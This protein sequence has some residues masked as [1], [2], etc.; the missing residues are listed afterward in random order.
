VELARHSLPRLQT[1]NQ[2]YL[3]D[4]AGMT[5]S[6]LPDS[7]KTIKEQ[8]GQ[9]M[10]QL[11]L[12]YDEERVYEEGT[13][14]I[15]GDSHGKH[16]KSRMFN[17][18]GHL[19]DFL[20]PNRVIHIGHA[21]DD[22]NDFSYLWKDIDNFTILAKRE[23]LSTLATINER[24]EE[25]GDQAYDIVRGEISLGDL[26]VANQDMIS[27]YVETFI[28]HIKRQILPGNVVTNLH[29]QELDSRTISVG[30]SIILSPGC[31]CENHIVKTIRQMDFT[32]GIQVK[33]SYPDGF[34]K[35]RK[36]RHKF[37]FWE[38]GLV[39]VHV[40]SNGKAYPIQCRIKQTS[41]GYTTSYMGTIVS[42]KGTHKPD[43]K[44]FMT[45]DA[46]CPFQD[47]NAL[48]IQRQIAASYSP[49]KCVNLGDIMRNQSFNHHQMTKNGA[50]IDALTAERA[51]DMMDESAH[52][53]WVLKKQ[54]EWADEFVLMY[55]NH[56]RFARDFVDR[57]PQLRTILDVTFTG[58]LSEL[59]LL[60]VPLKHV[61]EDGPVRFL[62][63]DIRMYGAKGPMMDKIAHTFGQ[64]SVVGHLHAPAIRYGCYMVGMS[65]LF[66]QEYNEPAACKWMHGCGVCDIFDGQAFISLI[67]I[68][69]YETCIGD[70]VYSPET[71]DEWD[72]PEYTSSISYSFSEE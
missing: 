30:H 3:L 62:H 47:N 48:D 59:D 35:Y 7:F 54:R 57:Y 15:V 37:R 26:T 40:D 42:E 56:E 52:V 6:D 20:K 41:K 18:L 8:A 70:T 50:H 44:H 10:H 65:G 13:Y 64:S 49:D 32:D 68:R 60:L 58:G 67:H 4:K 9:I 53:H 23:E 43:K 39:V 63:G 19:C 11:G 61:H 5:K 2:D 29:R 38:Q 45:T 71:P 12:G 25:N 28:G 55:G 17:L 51:L 46:H 14:I 36:M 21:I 33:L 27:D 22:D 34:S 66:D 31:L 72:L 16:T 1:I 24:L 69:D